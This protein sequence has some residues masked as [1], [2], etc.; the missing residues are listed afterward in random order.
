MT[1][2]ESRCDRNATNTLPGKTP[3]KPRVQRAPC[4]LRRSA[5][6]R[7]SLKASRQQPSEVHPPPH[8]RQHGW[9]LCEQLP[10]LRSGRLMRFAK[11]L[12]RLAERR[13]QPVLSALST[14]LLRAA[15]GS[16]GALLAGRSVLKA[17]L[18]PLRLQGKSKDKK[19]SGCNWVQARAPGQRGTRKTTD[20]LFPGRLESKDG[21]FGL[22][23]T[24]GSAGFFLFWGKKATPNPACLP[25]L[26][27]HAVRAWPHR[28]LF[29]RG[30][31]G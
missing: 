17:A 14:S 10:A 24:T 19:P 4:V 12:F 25:P 31:T 16:A 29:G 8:G 21:Q 26:S 18:P 28:H 15:S 2:A 22:G 30:R 23:D 5:Y 27:V 3:V 6:G 13:Q 7:R 11:Y 20:D 9:G 1:S